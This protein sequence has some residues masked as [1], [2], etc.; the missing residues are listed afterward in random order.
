MS[1]TFSMWGKCNKSFFLNPIQR[2][3]HIRSRHVWEALI[4]RNW[5]HG[6]LNSKDKVLALILDQDIADT[7]TAEWKVMNFP[8]LFK[9][10]VVHSVL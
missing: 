5:F 1:D 7:V 8:V 9:I 4:S 2:R 6:Y 10:L 3:L